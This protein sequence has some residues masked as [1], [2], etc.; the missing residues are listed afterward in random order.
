MEDELPL[1]RQGSPEISSHLGDFLS[2][3]W[4][5]FSQLGSF[6]YLMLLVIWGYKPGVSPFFPSATLLSVFVA[7]F[8]KK[9]YANKIHLNVIE[10]TRESPLRP[11][12]ARLWE[13]LFDWDHNTW[14][15]QCH[16]GHVQ[17]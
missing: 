3:V 17:P 16:G 6:F 9:G 14:C 15:L 13:L 8:W 2:T 10:L 4:G 12:S 11:I 1:Y 7:A 5:F